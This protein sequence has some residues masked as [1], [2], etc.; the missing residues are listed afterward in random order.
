MF[1]TLS[2]DSTGPDCTMLA[3]HSALHVLLRVCDDRLRGISCDSLIA[4]VSQKLRNNV[5]GQTDRQTVSFSEALG[6]L[7]VDVRSVPASTQH[8]VIKHSVSSL[9][10]GRAGR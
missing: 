4:G 1:G 2:G 9:S 7:S 3:S 5:E 10:S 6:M 8:T